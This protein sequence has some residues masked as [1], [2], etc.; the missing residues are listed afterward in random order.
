MQP[1][2]H[3]VLCNG[4]QAGGCERRQTVTVS[5]PLC[6]HKACWALAPLHSGRRRHAA[7]T[8]DLCCGQRRQRARAKAPAVARGGLAGVV[9]GGG[10]WPSVTRCAIPRLAVLSPR[11]MQ[12]A[13]GMQ[14]PP[15]TY[16]AGSGANVL[17]LRRP[18]WQE[19]GWR[20]VVSD[21]GSSHL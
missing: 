18:P 15:V 4:W 19:V 6:H 1:T 11:C 3:S 10:L 8:C 14:Q 21:G 13:V 20:G 16:S 9:S 12:V 2:P 5:D 17:E 7:A